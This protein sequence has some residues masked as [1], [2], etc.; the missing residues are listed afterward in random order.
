MPHLTALAPRP[1]QLVGGGL[2][3][4]LVPVGINVILN[5]GGSGQKINT[6]T[7]ARALEALGENPKVG[8]A[9]RGTR[10]NYFGLHSGQLKLQCPARNARAATLSGP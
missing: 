2:A 6:T 10:R 8:G 3:L 1:P 4:L 5:L 9:A 7:A